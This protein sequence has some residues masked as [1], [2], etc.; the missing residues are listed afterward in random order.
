[1]RAAPIVVAAVVTQV[2]GEVLA[3]DDAVPVLVAGGPSR[4]LSAQ[5]RTVSTLTPSSSVA[6]LIRNCVMRHFA[7][8]RR[9]YGSARATS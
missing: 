1:V 4:P 2:G 6:S 8:G 7:Y 9:I 3:V 5:R